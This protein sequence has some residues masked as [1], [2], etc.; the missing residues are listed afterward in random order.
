M[1]T[2]EGNRHSWVQCSQ[3]VPSTGLKR[4]V[5]KVCAITA[6]L[7]DLGPRSIT[8]PYCNT[9]NTNQSNGWDTGQLIHQGPKCTT[10]L[11][12]YHERPTR[13]ASFLSI[14]SRGKKQRDNSFLPPTVKGRKNQRQ[15]QKTDVRVNLKE[16]QTLGYLGIVKPVTPVEGVPLRGISRYKKLF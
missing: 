10:R 7:S 3:V 14:R 13:G 4:D 15:K 2:S 11:M 9:T 6:M 5:S 1:V 8:S 12:G 16:G